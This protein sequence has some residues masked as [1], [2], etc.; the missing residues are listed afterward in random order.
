M[1][2]LLLSLVRTGLGMV[3]EG[4]LI[5]QVVRRAVSAV[6]LYV[7][8]GIFAIAAVVFAYLFLYRV[9]AVRIGEE[10]AA[11]A[12]CGGNLLVIAIILI[13]IALLRPR[14]RVAPNPLLGALA[15]GVDLASGPGLD[16]GIAIGRRLR[17]TVKR[18]VRKAAPG[19]T[20]AA[21]LLG[22]IIGIRP[23][24][25]GFFRS[26]TPAETQG[27]EGRRR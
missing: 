23:Q 25:L 3:V 21:A 7:V 1:I 17:A 14:R 18:T 4:A 24:T 12:L 10:G 5:K 13:G 11:A 22:V 15:G 26:K 6:I 27:R 2:G 8:I 9:L 16:A 19:M 20:V